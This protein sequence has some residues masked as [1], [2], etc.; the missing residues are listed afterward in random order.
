M[1][2]NL[3]GYRVYF[4]YEVFKHIYISS[5][6]DLL[7]FLLKSSSIMGALLAPPPAFQPTPKRLTCARITTLHHQCSDA[8][9][10][11]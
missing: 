4:T 2:E 8:D 10:E 3:V 9:T 7:L 1:N 5:R 11:P 6:I